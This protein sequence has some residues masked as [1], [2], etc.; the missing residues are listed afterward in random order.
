MPTKPLNIA[1][2]KTYYNSQ[3][4]KECISIYESSELSQIILIRHGKP[5]LQR[6]GRFNRE[7][8][9]AYHKN[10]D[11]ASILNFSRNPLCT[12]KLP[13]MRV[14]HSNKRR[15]EHT[16]ELLFPESKFQLFP[17]ELFR[18]FER[19]PVEFFDIKMPIKWWNLLSRFLWFL[20]INQKEYEKFPKTHNRV[21]NGADSLINETRKN[22]L[23]ILVAH[24]IYNKFMGLELYARGW[25]KVMDQGGGFLAIKIYVK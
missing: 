15:A 9:L 25:R 13:P 19:R 4:A 23:A 22:G 16:A 17:N 11:A 12:A 10:Y 18:E 7:E 1:K 8:A 20:G 21:K 2:L 24:G 5:D 3:L 6:S 14:F